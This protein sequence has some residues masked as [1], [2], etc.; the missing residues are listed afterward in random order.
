MRRGPSRSSSS[1]A[2]RQSSGPDQALADPAHR[3]YGGS[4]A[5]WGPS[6]LVITV[7]PHHDGEVLASGIAKQVFH[8]LA[9]AL[10][11]DGWSLISSL[12]LRRGW[13]DIVEVR[14]HTPLSLRQREEMASLKLAIEDALDGQRH[15][16]EI[17]WDS[18]G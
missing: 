11:D 17:V 14:I 4:V 3:R 13:G 8:A 1:R 7:P 16:V 18:F 9:D 5:H 10:P 6:P 15:R 12:K 2:H